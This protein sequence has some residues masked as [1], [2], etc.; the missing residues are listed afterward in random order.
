MKTHPICLFV[1]LAGCAHH[2]EEKKET[3]PASKATAPTSTPAA[4]REATCNNDL[5]CTPSQLCIRGKCVDVSAGLAECSQVQVHF[6]LNASEL[7]PNDKPALERAG[8]CLKADHHLHVSVAGN[9]D[10]RG[11][12]EYNLALGDRRATVV[13]K[14]LQALGSSPAQL[15]TVS[16]GKENPLCAEHDEACWAKNRRADLKATDDATP[17]KHKH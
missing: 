4:S 12:E 14:Y 8:R 16:Y 2:A 13:S 10:E 3:T 6:A 1:L 9:A 5:D 17:K 11:T 7:D 15:S